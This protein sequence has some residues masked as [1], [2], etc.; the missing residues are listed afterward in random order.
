MSE[1]IDYRTPESVCTNC[2][3]KMTAAMS[4]PDGDR[5]PGPGD[6]SIC[7]ECHHLMAY[8]DDMS[9]RDLTDAEVGEAAGDL[10]IVQAMNLLGLADK[11]WKATEKRE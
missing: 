3:H 4:T 10:T 9:L 5:A 8:A 7:I 11:L 6:W 2:G 1:P